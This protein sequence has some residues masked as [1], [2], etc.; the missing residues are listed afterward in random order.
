MSNR[1]SASLRNAA[2]FALSSALVFGASIMNGGKVDLKSAGAMAFGPDGILFVGDSMGGTVVAIDTQDTKAQ[3]GPV[4]VDV[5]NIND[6]VAALLGTAADQILI[7]DVKVNPLSKSVYLSVARG[8]GPDGVAVIVKMDA[9]G[10]LTALP[11][12]NMQHSSVNLPNPP[13]SA[14]GGRGNPRMDTITDMSFIKGN[15]IVAGLS[16]EEFASDLRS[17]PWPFQS[18]DKGANIE[19]YHGSHGRY[20][21][22][23]PVR[24][25]IPYTIEGQDYI[26]AAYT[27]TPLVKIP[28][29]SL[30]AGAKVQGTT[31]AELGAGNKPLDM[32]AYKK[33]GH[34]YILLANSNRGVMKLSADQ[35]E[36]Y[37]PI[38]AQT[39]ITGVPY[40]TIADLKGVQH[41]VKVDDATALILS[42][43][44]GTL[45]LKTIALP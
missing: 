9:S 14:P 33:A 45:D 35:L 40:Q 21:T 30:K 24:T 12:D 41:L 6:K 22:Q 16:N 44:S 13:A 19:M 2:V 36:N 4:T 25:F 17:I 27:C 31:I 28:V 8:R 32:V 18:A 10:K 1:V 11:L 26:L 38:T 20:E 23:S 42:N 43:G 5:K 39:E 7:N 3:S 37:K 15:L 29:S 34:D